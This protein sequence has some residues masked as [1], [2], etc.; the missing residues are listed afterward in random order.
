MEHVKAIFE[1]IKAT[2]KKTEKEALILAHRDDEQFQEALYFLLNPYI[3]TGL[4]EKKVNKKVSAYYI[5]LDN[6]LEV[7][8]FLRDNNT[9]T[10]HV[11]ATV[12]GFIAEQ[13]EDMWQFYKELF[14]KSY[15]LGCGDKIVNKVFGYGFIP[16]FEC[17]LA[18]KYFD[19]PDLDGAEFTLTTKMNGYRCITII[20]EDG[21]ILMY[22][23]QGNPFCGL[24][25]IEKEIVS[26]GIKNV[27]LDGEL[28][29][30][31]RTGLTNEQQ[32]NKTK[33]IVSKDGVK[34]GIIY[35]MFDII[36]KSEWD[37]RTGN[38]PYSSRRKLIEE[39]CAPLNL[40]EALPVIYSGSDDSMVLKYLD[41]AREN[42][43]EGIM[44]NINDA[45]YAFKRVSGLLKVKVMQ[46]ADLEIV[47]VKEGKGD[48]KGMAG[49]I[50]VDY[51]GYPVGAG[52]LKKKDC[53]WFWEHQDEAIGRVARIQ[54]FQE[55]TNEQGTVSLLYANFRELREIGKEVSYS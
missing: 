50:I 49:S 36:A 51:K 23:R 55:T 20:D 31:D 37:C 5:K 15:T 21:T 11:I 4:S 24:I 43:E 54:Y 26:R 2:S 6:C 13:P 14:T 34:H 1:Q 16:T 33:K 29:I 17:M 27:V 28:L 9:G 25:D 22:S 38:T 39:Y 46:E 47:G 12:Q 32:Y 30:E 18:E 53:K 3:V 35:H 7:M 8:N 44:V 40:I 48:R 19:N 45:F 41:E 52:G 10:D 42:G